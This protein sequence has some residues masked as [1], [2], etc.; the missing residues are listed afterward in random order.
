MQ[1]AVQ[2]KLTAQWREENPSVQNASELLKRIEA[3]K[4]QLIAEKK[5][6]KEKPLPLVEDEDK[7][8]DLPVLSFNQQ[9]SLTFL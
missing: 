4:Q 2:G 7:P 9:K 8:Y 5:I 3:E 1:L 6:K